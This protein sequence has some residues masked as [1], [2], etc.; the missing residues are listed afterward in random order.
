MLHKNGR[1]ERNT[2]RREYV[3]SQ[4]S[5]VYSS[6]KLLCTR[7][8][9]QN[10]DFPALV[11]ILPTVPRMLCHLIWWQKGHTMASLLMKIHSNYSAA[12]PMSLLSR[13]ASCFFSLSMCSCALSLV[14]ICTSLSTKLSTSLPFR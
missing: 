10:A 2:D 6:P 4:C 5:A 9:M 11:T 1:V 13:E 14:T 8:D 3:E 12:E 7:H